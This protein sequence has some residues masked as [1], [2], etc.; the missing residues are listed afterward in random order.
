MKSIDVLYFCCAEV[1][2][3]H[4]GKVDITFRTLTATDRS[5]DK[6]ETNKAESRSKRTA[7]MSLYNNSTNFTNYDASCHGTSSEDPAVMMSIRIYFA[8]TLSFVIIGLVG[9]ALSMLVF[10]SREMQGVSSN[11]YLLTLASMSLLVTF[12]SRRPPVGPFAGLLHPFHLLRCYQVNYLRKVV[13]RQCLC[14]LSTLLSISNV[15]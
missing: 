13:Y 14:V 9:N 2:G 3:T 1:D 6:T 15:I 8:A 12:V 10:S 11:V 7:A 5:V 4:P